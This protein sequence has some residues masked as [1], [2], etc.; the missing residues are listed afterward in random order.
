[1]DVTAPYYHAMDIVALPSYRE[2][3]PDDGGA[4]SRRGGGKPVVGSRATGMADA[5]DEEW[6]GLLARWAMSLLWQVG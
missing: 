5:V 1:M 3:L 2:G 6:T 4:G